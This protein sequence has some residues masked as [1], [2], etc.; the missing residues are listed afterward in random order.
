MIIRFPRVST[1]T[2]DI[3]I[4]KS[5]VKIASDGNSG[6]AGVGVEVPLVDEDEVAAGV[7]IGVGVLV[8]WSEAKIADMSC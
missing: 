7:V 5:T 2:T 6:V 8:V 3:I 1:A 4:V